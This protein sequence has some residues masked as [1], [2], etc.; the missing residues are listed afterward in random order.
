MKS[1]CILLGVVN[2]VIIIWYSRKN[3]LKSRAF[4]SSK[5]NNQWSLLYGRGTISVEQSLAGTLPWNSGDYLYLRSTPPILFLENKIFGDWCHY[6]FYGLFLQQWHH[7]RDISCSLVFINFA[8]LE[9]IV[10]KDSILTK[11]WAVASVDEQTITFTFIN[12][13]HSE[14]YTVTRNLLHN[15]TKT[16]HHTHLGQKL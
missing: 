7:E 11:D 8:T 15:S 5:G 1:F 6:A 3:K 4:S 2:I 13:N 9:V 12:H 10:V 16:H 14:E